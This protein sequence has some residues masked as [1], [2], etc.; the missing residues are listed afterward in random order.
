MESWQGKHKWAKKCK[1]EGLVVGGGDVQHSDGEV[2]SDAE[3]D[4]PPGVEPEAAARG[5]DAVIQSGAFI[6]LRH[7]DGG[8]VM[9]TGVMYDPEPDPVRLWTSRERKRTEPEPGPP[10]KPN[11]PFHLP[12]VLCAAQIILQR[13]SEK[14]ACGS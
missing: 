2:G 6:E 14:W 8:A 12:F 3:E 10:V 5:D 13:A 7:P 4:D 9:A 11:S 1:R